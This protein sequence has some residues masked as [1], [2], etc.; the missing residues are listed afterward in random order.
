MGD[1]TTGVLA[2]G[3]VVL[4]VMGDGREETALVAMK[5]TLV[6]AL[7]DVVS[8]WVL[9]VAVVGT[10][11]AG[12]SKCKLRTEVPFEHLTNILSATFREERVRVS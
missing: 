4:G 11:V 9:N 8:V 7:I 6:R 5:P 10:G 2:L 3:T 12:I 1:I